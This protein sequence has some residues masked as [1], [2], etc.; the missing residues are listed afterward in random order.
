MLSTR[1]INDLTQLSVYTNCENDLWEK[2]NEKIKK[3]C[4]KDNENNKIEKIRKK[5]S[6]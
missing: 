3:I 5:M 2:G 1:G 4:K 6:H